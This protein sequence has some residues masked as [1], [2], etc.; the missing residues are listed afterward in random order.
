MWNDELPCHFACRGVLPGNNFRVR[1]RTTAVR[2]EI[3]TS[4]CPTSEAFM[5]VTLRGIILRNFDWIVGFPARTQEPAL[6]YFRPASNAHSVKTFS[7]L[8]D[9]IM[10]QEPSTP[11]TASL[12][13]RNFHLQCIGTP[14]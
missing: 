8:N 5:F 13:R 9:E 3:F 11:A 12:Q 4:N 7:L 1:I 6:G 2:E 14:E 10:N